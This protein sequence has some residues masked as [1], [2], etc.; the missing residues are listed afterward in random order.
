MLCQVMFKKNT[1]DVMT[2]QVVAFMMCSL[3]ST[4]FAT[5]GFIGSVNVAYDMHNA[6]ETAVLVQQV[7][8]Q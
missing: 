3:F 1:N 6:D 5:Y 7:S 8:E 2:F 4:A